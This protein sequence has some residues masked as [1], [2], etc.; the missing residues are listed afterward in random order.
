[1]LPLHRMQPPRFLVENDSNAFYAQAINEDGEGSL[2]FSSATYEPVIALIDCENDPGDW[3]G[4]VPCDIQ[5]M[6]ARSYT[7]RSAPCQST[8]A[9]RTQPTG[10]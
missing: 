3:L 8:A 1:M 5:R 2:R 4:V 7:I 6:L 9:K 10:H